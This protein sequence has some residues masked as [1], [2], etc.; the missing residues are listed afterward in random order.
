MRFQESFVCIESSSRSNG[1]KVY[2]PIT[3]FN[4][5]HS[6]SEPRWMN[7][8]KVGLTTPEMNNNKEDTMIYYFHSMERV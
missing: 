1:E 5:C 8:Q 3:K 4:N 2:K 7:S 6:I